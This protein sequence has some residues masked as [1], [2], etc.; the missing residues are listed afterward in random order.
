MERELNIDFEN[1]TD[2][3]GEDEFKGV[4]MNLEPPSPTFNYQN[5]SKAFLT[6]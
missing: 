2:L 1:L 6:Y 5:S 3:V 4:S